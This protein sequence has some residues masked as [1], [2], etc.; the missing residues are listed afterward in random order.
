MSFIT[1][2]INWVSGL[3]QGDKVKVIVGVMSAFA[4]IIAAL[5]KKSPKVTAK[6]GS[7]AAGRDMIGNNISNSTASK[8]EEEK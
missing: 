3:S 5:L 4:V 8:H 1:N 7:N 2:I 6:N